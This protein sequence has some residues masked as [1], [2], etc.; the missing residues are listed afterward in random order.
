MGA[1]MPRQMCTPEPVTLLKPCYGLELGL[2]DNLRSFCTQRYAGDV[3]TIFC[4]QRLD[5]PA[6][7]ILNALAK[8]Y[9]GQVSVVITPSPPVVNGKVQNMIGGLAHAR[10]DLIIITDSD[11]RVGADYVATMLAPFADAHTGYVCSLYR[12]VE[13]KTLAE[14]FEA[15]SFNA[16]FV[17]Q[18]LFTA[19]TGLAPFCLGASM[20]FRKSDLDTVGGMKAMLP[21][22]VE[23]YEIGKRITA[24]G[25]KA[26][27]VPHVVEM[28]V[29]LPRLRDWWQHQVYWDVNTK[30]ANFPGYVA[31]VLT[32][33]VP[34]AVLFA[35]LRGGDDLSLIIVL[36]AVLVR[37]VCAQQVMA[38]I[39]DTDVSTLWL[40]PFR[41]CLA[42]FTWAAAL[43]QRSYVWRG[44]K[45]RLRSDGSIIPRHIDDAKT[46]GVENGA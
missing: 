13:A 42:L 36:A 4:V 29:A 12:I 2:A 10:H 24:L 43:M 32:R 28:R 6:L 15:L 7:P 18:I 31:S 38:H 1:A 37:S 27:L 9:P 34:F 39:G 41:D 16:D 46:L 20:A 5:D 17:P 45:F 26:V 35:L 21:Y 40:L 44:I 30:A 33:A 11:V 25:K 23:D 3:Q 8:D 19:W 14:K 22:I